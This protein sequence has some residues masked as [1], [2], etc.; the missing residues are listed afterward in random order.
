MLIV[1][2]ETNANKKYFAKLEHILV[3]SIELSTLKN[4][5]NRDDTWQ[6]NISSSSPI[7]LK[8]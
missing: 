5:F 3:V 2:K 7:Y 6:N 4:R 8:Q 1:A